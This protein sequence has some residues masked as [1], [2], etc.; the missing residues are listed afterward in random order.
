MNDLDAARRALAARH[1][2][3]R[4]ARGETDL[5][6]LGR[7]CW[8]TSSRT[9]RAGN[10]RVGCVA[11]CLARPE[12]ADAVIDAATRFLRARGDVDCL[13]GSN[14]SHPAWIRLRAQAT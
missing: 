10:L 7:P 12:D 5:L 3:A 2:A 6:R 13:V 11:D 1:P 14:Q 9:I 4:A 8:T